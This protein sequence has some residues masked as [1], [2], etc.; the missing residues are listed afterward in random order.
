MQ[1]NQWCIFMMMCELIKNEFD[2]IKSINDFVIIQQTIQSYSEKFCLIEFN[3]LNLY[4][5]VD[6]KG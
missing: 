4:S 2:E 1:T 3:L 5:S 6:L